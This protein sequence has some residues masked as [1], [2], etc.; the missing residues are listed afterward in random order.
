MHSADGYRLLLFILDLS[1]LLLLFIFSWFWGFSA[2]FQT[3]V[4]R[5]CILIFFFIKFFSFPLPSF[6]FLVLPSDTSFFALYT[7]SSHWSGDT[8]YPSLTDAV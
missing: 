5:H 6:F 7:F 2:G 3:S 1:L 4:I 8:G